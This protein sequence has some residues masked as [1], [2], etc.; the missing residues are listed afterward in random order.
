MDQRQLYHAIEKTASKDYRSDEELLRNVVQEVINSDQMRI[1]G[2][3]IWKL[4]PRRNVYVIVD[5]I[6]E[7]KSIP[8][9]FAIKVSEYPDFV[10]VG[11]KKTVL[12]MER[13]PDLI[14][15]GI[16]RFSATGVGDKTKV[17]EH[18]LYQYI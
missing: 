13:N 4:V 11:T 2:G 12:N 17:K 16:Q 10:Q 6:G 8:E 3:R 7:V 15:T 14:K 5:Q 18:V 9:G 1:K